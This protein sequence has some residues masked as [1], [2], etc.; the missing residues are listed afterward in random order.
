MYTVYLRT[1][2]NVHIQWLGYIK[3]KWT[4]GDTCCFT[5]PALSRTY[6]TINVSFYFFNLIKL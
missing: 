5:L 3:C 1:I 6:T 2:Y 4:E